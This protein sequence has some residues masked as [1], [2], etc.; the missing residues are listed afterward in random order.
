[1]KPAKLVDGSVRIGRRLLT[2]AERARLQR[3][4]VKARR[5]RVVWILVIVLIPFLGIGILIAGTAVSKSAFV[6]VVF[7]SMIALGW[8][9]LTAKEGLQIEAIQDS[10]E[11]TEVD[12][13]EDFDEPGTI[14]EVI[15]G[16]NEIL[17]RSGR[18]LV[19]SQL[20]DVRTPPAPAPLV[21]SSGVERPLSPEEK[22]EIGRILGHMRREARKTIPMSTLILPLTISAALSR[23]GPYVVFGVIFTV[24]SVWAIVTA[25]KSLTIAKK[26]ATDLS[27]GH[28]LGEGDEEVFPESKLLWTRKG[29]PAPWRSSHMPKKRKI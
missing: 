1:M 28:V 18:T 22:A 25:I 15:V 8:L 5:M 13:F 12:Q 11:A 23:Q 24:T 27:V 3:R 9:Y 21:A 26:I 29:Q 14:T 20:A 4:Y 6:P 17:S 10:A 19:K 16:S 2:D 7:G